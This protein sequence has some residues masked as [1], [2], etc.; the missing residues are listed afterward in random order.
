MHGTPS[1][2]W[3][4]QTLARNCFGVLIWG[5]VAAGDSGLPSFLCRKRLTLCMVVM[6]SSLGYSSTPVCTCNVLLS[7]HGR[8]QWSWPDKCKHR[9]QQQ[10]ALASYGSLLAE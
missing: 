3:M 9:Q 5:V 4:A 1:E 8:T 7:Q 6:L 2:F 10:T